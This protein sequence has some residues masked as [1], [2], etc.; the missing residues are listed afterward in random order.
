MSEFYNWGRDVIIT[1]DH[2]NIA[3]NKPVAVKADSTVSTGTRYKYGRNLN[4]K[5]K[6]VLKISKPENYMLPKFDINTEYL[7]AEDGSFFVYHNQYHKY[8]N[9]YKNSFQHGG[10]SLDE[11]IVPLVKLKNKKN[12]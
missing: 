3:V 2:G 5:S 9:M 1:S 7:I 12:D 10:I 4:I 11:I 6:N 8:I